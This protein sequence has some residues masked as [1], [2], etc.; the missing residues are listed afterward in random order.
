MTIQGAGGS[1][2]FAKAGGYAA[3]A[4]PDLAQTAGI[5]PTVYHRAGQGQTASLEGL[6]TIA[7]EAV[8]AETRPRASKASTPAAPN[9]KWTAKC[10]TVDE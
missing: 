10:K 3:R 2:L 7:C 9:A 6:R 5:W 4:G 1:G 8:Q